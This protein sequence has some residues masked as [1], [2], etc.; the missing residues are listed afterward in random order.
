[1]KTCPLCGAVVY[2]NDDSAACFRC[3][4]SGARVRLEIYDKK[5]EAEEP[6][7]AFSDVFLGHMN[8]KRMRSKNIE[9]GGF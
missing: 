8:Y 4:N 6:S 2:S 7:K 1:M 5:D 9:R 3:R